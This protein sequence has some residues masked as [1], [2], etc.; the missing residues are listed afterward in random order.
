MDLQ[1]DIAVEFE[2]PPAACAYVLSHQMCTLY[3]SAKVRPELCLSR[4]LSDCSDHRHVSL[5]YD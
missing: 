3:G 5:R 2:S 4:G 1:I